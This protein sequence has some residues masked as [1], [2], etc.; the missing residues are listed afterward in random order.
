[1]RSTQPKPNP[2]PSPAAPGP[3]LPSCSALTSSGPFLLMACLKVPK[4]LGSLSPPHTQ[5]LHPPDLGQGPEATHSPWAPWGARQTWL[6]EGLSSRPASVDPSF[7]GGTIDREARTGHPECPV[8]HT[9]CRLLFPTSPFTIS[10]IFKTRVRGPGR[11]TVTTC[12]QLG[13]V[14]HWLCYP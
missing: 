9:S 6:G 11:L 12:R 7:P 13:M 3:L 2:S 4:T 5:R 8:L 1:M 14:P 10:S